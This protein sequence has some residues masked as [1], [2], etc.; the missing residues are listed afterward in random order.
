MEESDTL[1][2]PNRL[3]SRANIKT[4]ESSRVPTNKMGPTHT[5]TNERMNKQTNKGTDSKQETRE[6]ERKTEG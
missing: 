3:V 2:A 6:R 5:K 1:V 4:I